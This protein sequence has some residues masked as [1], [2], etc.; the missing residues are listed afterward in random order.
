MGVDGG[1]HLETPGG[2]VLLTGFVGICHDTSGY[3]EVCQDFSGFGNVCRDLL[4]FNGICEDLSVYVAIHWDLS[5]YVAIRWDSPRHVGF[6][7]NRQDS[8]GVRLFVGT[9]RDLPGFR[10]C[11][12][13]AYAGTGGTMDVNREG[14]CGSQMAR[15]EM[16]TGFWSQMTPP[17]PG[18]DRNPSPLF[19]D[20]HRQPDLIPNP[21]PIPNPD[22]NP[23][24]FP[25]KK[26]N[27]NS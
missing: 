13:G 15:G 22:P 25:K 2:L 21:T 27:L 18:H 24:P 20:P 12:W 17:I 23:N 10:G 4:G 5:V 3:V 8:L 1:K 26:H 11:R 6:V 16:G 9:C 19:P 14:P 7:G